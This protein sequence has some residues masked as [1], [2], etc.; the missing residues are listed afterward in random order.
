[1]IVTVDCDSCECITLREGTL[2]WGLKVFEGTRG[3]P[4][5]EGSIKN[6]I[7][8]VETDGSCESIISTAANLEGTLPVGT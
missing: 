7:R 2:F 8:I 5:C 4:F 1:M 6:L 3:E